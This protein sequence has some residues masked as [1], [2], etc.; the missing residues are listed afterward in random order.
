MLIFEFYKNL[1]K[2]VFWEIFYEWA[3]TIRTVDMSK[4]GTRFCPADKI[5]ERGQRIF[6]KIINLNL[7]WGISRKMN[8]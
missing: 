1:H 5:E 7:L 3:G 4:K 2:Y 8:L 6:P